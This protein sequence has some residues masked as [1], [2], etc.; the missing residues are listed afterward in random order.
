MSY[1]FRCFDEIKCYIFGH[2][3]YQVILSG[4]PLFYLKVF[5][6]STFLSIATRIPLFEIYY[7]TYYSC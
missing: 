1:I 6:I 2:T 4:K 5:R 7:L 3:F